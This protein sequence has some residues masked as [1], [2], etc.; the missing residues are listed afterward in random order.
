M[1]YLDPAVFRVHSIDV[2]SFRT[3]RSGIWA[4]AREVSAVHALMLVGPC[5]MRRE[6]EILRGRVLTEGPLPDLKRRQMSR[7]NRLRIWLWRA[8]RSAISTMC[9]GPQNAAEIS[10]FQ[11]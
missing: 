6:L 9:I 1:R 4:S 8:L 7:P 3:P 2:L 11:V 5:A 10:T